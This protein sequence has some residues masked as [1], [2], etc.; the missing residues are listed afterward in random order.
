M[1]YFCKLRMIGLFIA[2][3]FLTACGGSEDREQEYFNR[4]Q[5]HFNEG[6]LDK[7]RVELKNVLQI[8]PKNI[9]ARYLMALLAEKSQDWRKMYG[10]LLGVVQ[11]NPERL[12][13]QNKLG[14]LFLLSGQLDKALENSELVLTKEINNVDAL[15]LKAAVFMRKGELL[16]SESIIQSVLVSNPGQV[17]ATLMLAKQYGDNKKYEDALTLIDSAIL[18]K[19]NDINLALFK[20][21]YLVALKSFEDAEKV[22]L[23]LIIS[24]PDKSSLHY[25]FAK[26]Y[27]AWGK[28]DMGAKVLRD[29]IASKP[30]AAEPKLALAEFLLQ[31]KGKEE[32]ETAL[33]NFIKENTGDY[34]LRFALAKVYKDSPDQAIDVLNEIVAADEDS[35]AGLKANNLLAMFAV[36]QGDKDKA[37]QL[38]NE[39][40][41]KDP[42]NSEALML[43][44]SLLVDE[45]DYEAAIADLRMVMRD[46][47]DSEKAFMLSANAHLKSGF[48]DLA[49]DSLEKVLFLNPKN[50][51]VRKDLAR[52]M[53]RNKDEKGAVELLEGVSGSDGSNDVLSMLVDLHIRTKDWEKAIEVAQSIADTDDHVG[54]SSYKLAQIFF[55]QKKYALAVEEYIKVLAVKPLAIDILAQLS[56]SYLAMGEPTK[57]EDLLAKLIVQHPENA[58][59]LNLN[60]VLYRSLKQTDKALKIFEQ[61]ISLDKKFA[62]GYRNLA[63]I[64]ANKN[65]INKAQEIL[66][67]GLIAIP[68]DSR[69]LIA[70]ASLYEKS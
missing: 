58:S 16:K 38:L 15:I 50:T 40:I 41:K 59:L 52:L 19:P 8:N 37:H 65:N 14:K 2:V 64:F 22:F 1:L 54:L 60:G 24:H 3:V 47:P 39:I 55:A 68:D 56:K 51:A 67:Q 66:K 33:Q 35:L 42:G 62:P 12:E 20:I 23:S 48:F 32:A 70:Q 36:K 29:Y 11:E 57:A 4:A 28:V 46:E 21:N 69:L 61:V 44:S 26:F 5:S 27:I 10:L 7:T 34:E 45:G 25:N 63:S 53:V 13:A 6:N 43:R 18:L 17:E 31:Q 49:E 9:D 30:E